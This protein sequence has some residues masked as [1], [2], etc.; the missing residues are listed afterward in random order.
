MAPEPEQ[1]IIVER[2]L[3]DQ[4]GSFQGLTLDIARYLPVLLDDRH[5]RFVPQPDAEPDA[6]LKQL[7]PISSLSMIIRSISSS[8][9]PM[10]SAQ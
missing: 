2:R 9:P 1:V 3:L 5:P 6:S 4:C 10:P 7:P 8:P